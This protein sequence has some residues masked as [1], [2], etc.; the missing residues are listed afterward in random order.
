MAEELDGSSSVNAGEVPE[1][2]KWS[3]FLELILPRA[4]DR[5]ELEAAAWHK[6]TPTRRKSVFI[7]LQSEKPPGLTITGR[8][9]G[10]G[11]TTRGDRKQG[12]ELKGKGGREAGEEM[13]VRPSHESR[14]SRG[15]LT[16]T[17]GDE[18]VLSHHGKH[19]KPTACAP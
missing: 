3:V 19:Q 6:Q 2:L 12:K 10:G 14:S 16:P 15:R 17:A 18:E 4:Q 7:C 9:E 1:F 11:K 8:G 5:W 13:R